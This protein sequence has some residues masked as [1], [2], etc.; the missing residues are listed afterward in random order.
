MLASVCC[1]VVGSFLLAPSSAES[2][3]HSLHLK[4]TR[5]SYEL[6]VV[7]QPRVFLMSERTSSSMIGT[8]MA[9]LATF[10]EAGILPP[11][12]TAQANQVIHGLIQLQST[13]IKSASA[14]LAAYQMAAEDFW[15][16]EHPDRQ[17]GVL[18]EKGLTLRVLEALIIYDQEQPMWNDPKIAS[19]MQEF[20]VS[21]ADW[22]FIVE[23]FHK[24]N[25]VFRDQERSMYTVY[26]A[27]RLKLPGGKP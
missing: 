24:A 10:D 23:L 8:I 16:K 9:L 1:F 26:D 3:G 7:K 6:H 21:Q 19:A 12:G 20:N 22:L 14:E 5:P 11:E 25:I 18:Q 4:N 17:D 2:L 27:W 13:L 15:R